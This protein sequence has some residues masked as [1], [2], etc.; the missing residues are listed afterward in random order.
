V[1][2]H[3]L[4]S[5]EF[6][7]DPHPTL[8]RLRAEDP[9]HWHAGLGMFVLTRYDDV[10]ALTRSS[11][12]SSERLPR[13]SQGMS[14]EVAGK[15]AIFD[16]F[17]GHWMNLADP[18]RHTRLRALLG[19]AFTPQMV[20]ALRPYVQEVVDECIDT[21]RAKG[22]M[23]V[24]AD[25][26][27]PVPMA[28]ICRM[29]GIPRDDGRALKGWTEAIMRQIGARDLTPEVVEMAL[30]GVEGL[31]AYFRKVIAER[32]RTPGDDLLSAL[33]RADE[34][35]DVMS[36]EEL[37]STAALLLVAGHETT[38]FLI[39]NAVLALLRN[40]G[41]LARLRQAPALVESAVEE[42]LRYEAPVF[43]TVKRAVEEVEIGGRKIAAG[44]L[45]MG[46][47][48]AANRDPSRF[49]EPDRMDIGRKDNRHFGFGVGIHYCIG[50]PLA[51]LETT[52]ALLGIVQRLPGLALAGEPLTPVPSLLMHGVQAL[53]VTFAV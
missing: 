41:E 9:V 21:A 3:D 10:T 45:V 53:P 23:E 37:I 48:A 17:L 31:A 38:T 44:Q 1:I 46:M 52:I 24:V 7:A 47:F 15:L 39:S 36:E 8:H 11:A 30:G 35:G 26:A 20:E 49:P 27:Y 19:R 42:V 4:L 28:V 25:L 33:V 6:L 16:R 43:Q 22:Q 12:F 14:A 13:V 40:P 51:R 2:V 29:L 5:P 34:A 32:R 50:A 18:P